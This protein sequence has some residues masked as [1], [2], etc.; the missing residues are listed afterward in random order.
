MSITLIDRRRLRLIDKRCERLGRES[1]ALYHLAVQVRMPLETLSA[2]AALAVAIAAIRNRAFAL[3][4][5]TE[6]AT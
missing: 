6:A 3:R 1:A 5:P 2:V 4:Y